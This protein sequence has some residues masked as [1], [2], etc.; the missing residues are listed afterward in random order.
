MRSMKK[1]GK[2]KAARAKG[3]TITI[4]VPH[5]EKKLHAF[6]GVWKEHIHDEIAIHKQLLQGRQGLQ[7]H[8]DETIRIHK[9]FLQ[10]LQKI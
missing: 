8:L 2:K 3:I 5:A 10:K 4:N 1:R 6:L 7:K 9:K